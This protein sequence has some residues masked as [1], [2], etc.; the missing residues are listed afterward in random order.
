MDDCNVML[1][2]DEEALSESIMLNK[3]SK[4]LDVWRDLELVASSS[5]E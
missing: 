4:T 2:V 5:E 3:G 1:L